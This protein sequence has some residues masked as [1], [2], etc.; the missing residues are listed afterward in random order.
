MKHFL[1]TTGLFFTLLLDKAR[2]V[3]VK[4]IRNSLIITPPLFD[5]YFSRKY[6]KISHGTFVGRTNCHMAPV[7]IYGCMVLVQ[8]KFR[9]L[10]SCKGLPMIA[11]A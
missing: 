6:R 5:Y 10:S 3:F 11:R 8:D 2:L 1:T 9:A 4:K 7:S